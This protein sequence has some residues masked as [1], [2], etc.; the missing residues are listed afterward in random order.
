MV[1]CMFTACQTTNNNTKREDNRVIGRPPSMDDDPFADAALPSIAEKTDTQGSIDVPEK[2][3]GQKPAVKATPEATSPTD[4]ATTPQPKN[5]L[6][7]NTKPAVAMVATPKATTPSPTKSKGP[8][9]YSC[10]RLCPAS[11]TSEDCSKSKED[12]ICGWG[13]APSSEDAMK[14]AQ[15]QC[16]AVLEMVR[17]GAQ[18]SS[19]SGQCPVAS[20]R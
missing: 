18:W 8:Q 3:V 7:T 16:N 10:V 9:C 4:P 17:D 5:T 20:C 6:N 14:L 15:G 19:V 2:S 12:L 1:I 13:T 11:D